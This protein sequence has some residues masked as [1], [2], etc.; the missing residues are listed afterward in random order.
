MA[1]EACENESVFPGRNL[2]YMGIRIV[3]RAHDTGPNLLNTGTC[4]LPT[5]KNALHIAGIIIFC[6]F[7]KDTVIEIVVPLI[8]EWLKLG[9]RSPNNDT[10]IS[11]GVQIGEFVVLSPMNIGVVE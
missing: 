6:S 3:G 11:S 10:S 5:I 9:S 1:I 2:V 7:N 8:R 4:V